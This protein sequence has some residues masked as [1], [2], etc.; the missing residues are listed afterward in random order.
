MRETWFHKKGSDFASPQLIRYADDFVILHEDVRV[1]QRCQGIISEWLED[2]G[3]EL[4]PSKTRLVHTLKE[5]DQERPG[6]DFLGFNIRQYAVGKTHTAKSNQGK[7]LGFKTIIT[8]AKRS[9]REHHRQLVEIVK[10]HRTAPQAA[11]ISRLNPIIRG[12]SNY[13]STVVSKEIFSEQDAHL[14]RKLKAWGKRRHSQ[15]SEDWVS[16]K[17]WHERNGRNWIFAAKNGDDEIGTLLLHTA[18]PIVRHVKVKGQTSPF[19]GNLV[20]WSI[21]RGQH[22]ET[23]KRVAKLLKRQKGKCTHCNLV[24]RSGDI[25]EVDHKIPKSK[26]GKDTY[27]NWQLLHRHCHDTKTAKDKAAER[28][29]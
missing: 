15:K 28:C 12:W 16:K 9:Q 23:P 24:F 7:L 18:I 13:Y 22:P 3:L 4:K 5:H 8:P 26:G 17:Y 27:T 19:D 14:Y 11:L 25:M 20:Y 10:A 1:V 29:V 21:R 6:F 2:M